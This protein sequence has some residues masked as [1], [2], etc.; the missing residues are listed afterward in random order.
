METT[1]QTSTSGKG[2]GIAALIIGIITFI[3][4]I[5]PLLG[6]GAFW[7]SVIGLA[8]G[9]IG[10]VMAFKGQNAKKG[11]II[12]GFILC[13]VSTGVSAY[14]VSAINTAAETLNAMTAQ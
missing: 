3:W 7:P 8:L 9:T 4:S 6:A 5:I 14:W 2:L 11:V 10:L 1:T 12:A 13:I